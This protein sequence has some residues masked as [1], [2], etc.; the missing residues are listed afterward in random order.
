LT[1]DFGLGV[2]VGVLGVGF[3]VGDFLTGVL[4]IFGA[5]TGFSRGVSVLV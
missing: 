3:G 5:G 2:G 1:F 4:L